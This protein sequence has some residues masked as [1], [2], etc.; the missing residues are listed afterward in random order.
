MLL[1]AQWEIRKEG[2]K[3]IIKSSISSKLVD[4]RA[5]GTRGISRT[6]IDLT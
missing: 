6:N 5:V 1:S 3:K 2:I 4:I